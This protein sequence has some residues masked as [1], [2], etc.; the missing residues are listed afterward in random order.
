MSSHFFAYRPHILKARWI[1][2]YGASVAPP[3][4]K[5]ANTSDSLPTSRQKMAGFGRKTKCLTIPGRSRLMRINKRLTSKTHSSLNL[6]SPIKVI[7]LE[8]ALLSGIQRR[9]NFK[10]WLSAQSGEVFGGPDN[11]V[12]LGLFFDEY[13]NG[14]FFLMLEDIG[15]HVVN[16]RAVIRS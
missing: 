3:W 8:M 15:L 14:Y 16:S 9:G 1:A 11:F 7:C 2:R 5:Y 12:G 4:L 10:C 6:K 13:D